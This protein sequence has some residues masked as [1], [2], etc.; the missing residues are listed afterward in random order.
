MNHRIKSLLPGLV[1]LYAVVLLVKGGYQAIFLHKHHAAL[2]Q[3]YKE[4]VFFDQ[5]VYYYFIL[6]LPY[7]EVVFALL[8]FLRIQL[9]WPLY[10]VFL[11]YITATYFYLD[12]GSFLYLAYYFT[13]AYTSLLLSRNQTVPGPDYVKE[14]LSGKLLR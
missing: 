14:I 11:V 3:D 1:W 10:T 12:S 6:F 5:D 2:E 4:L 8:L 13:M 7:M 9:K